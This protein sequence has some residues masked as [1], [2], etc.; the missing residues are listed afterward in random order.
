MSN[1]YPSHS[2][3]HHGGGSSSSRDTGGQGSWRNVVGIPDSGSGGQPID[4]AL[5]GVGG[6]QQHSHQ[7]GGSSYTQPAAHTLEYQMGAH[8]P[9][10]ATFNC[11]RPPPW[12]HGQQ[13]R[14]GHRI[15]NPPQRSPQQSQPAERA[16]RNNNH[17]EDDQKA[18][19]SRLANQTNPKLDWATIA[20]EMDLTEA[21]CKCRYTRMKNDGEAGAR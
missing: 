8:I 9:N 1:Q 2:Y 12:T 3:P 18:K 13:L 19:L 10:Y 16:F 17:W 11:T 21:Q 15:Q 20:K 7:G 5:A 4:P 14:G 6:S